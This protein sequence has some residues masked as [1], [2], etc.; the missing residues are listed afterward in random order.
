MEI[1]GQARNDK[2]FMVRKSV[3]FA[4][5]RYALTP[6]CHSREGGNLKL[7]DTWPEIPAFAGMTDFAKTKG[8][9]YC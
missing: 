1:A 8:A 3:R 9:T 2:K 6:R 5:K 4:I 7:R